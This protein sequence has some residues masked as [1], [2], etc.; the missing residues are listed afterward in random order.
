M[1]NKSKQITEAAFRV[2]LKGGMS[3]LSFDTIAE[4]ANL[5]RQL[6]RYYYKDQEKL[7]LSLCDHLAAAYRDSML[8]IVAQDQ[9]GDRLKLFFD[10]YFDLLEDAPKPRDDQVY[11]Y[12]FAYAAESPPV[13]E[14]L[15][16][17]YGLLGQFVSTEIQLKHNTLSTAQALELSYLFVSLMYGHW[18]MVATLGYSESHRHITRNAVDRLIQSYLTDAPLPETDFKVWSENT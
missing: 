3:N 1:G 4:E 11:D 9:A 17:Q 7:M 13:N 5:T 2:L 18:K 8:Q 12:L 14:N 16:M 15:R 10:F 6:I